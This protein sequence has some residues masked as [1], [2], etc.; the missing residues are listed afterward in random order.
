MAGMLD[1]YRHHRWANDLVIAAYADLPDDLLDAPVVLAYG[2]IRD[3][4][5]PGR[6]AGDVRCKR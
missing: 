1:F 5:V 6:H 2:S 3:T 4:L